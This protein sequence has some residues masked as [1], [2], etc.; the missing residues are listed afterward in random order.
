MSEITKA[1]RVLDLVPVFSE[2]RNVRSPEMQRAIRN[3]NGV[4]VVDQRVEDRTLS[5]NSLKLF[6]CPDISKVLMN[7]MLFSYLNLTGGAL[8]HYPVES[9]QKWQR[10]LV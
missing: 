2:R 8:L 9:F 4:L 1:A 10:R 3:W 7:G 5:M 6:I